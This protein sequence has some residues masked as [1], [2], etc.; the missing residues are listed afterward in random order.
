MPAVAGGGRRCEAAE[1]H[2]W[3]EHCQ[4]LSL[5]INFCHSGPRGSHVAGAYHSLSLSVSP[6]LP[7][8]SSSS[9]LIQRVGLH[10]S[11][12][13]MFSPSLPPS[14]LV[15]PCLSFAFA[16]FVRVACCFHFSF[17]P[18]SGCSPL[19]P[20]PLS[21][22]CLAQR[23]QG[24]LIWY[25]TPATKSST[26]HYVVHVHSELP[27]LPSSPLPSPGQSP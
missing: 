5:I 23:S 18:L 13:P 4:S 19:Y 26:F 7:S 6:S 15:S 9:P 21:L 14:S 17:L 27:P 3:R 8:P 24:E 11:V 12:P 1:S 16:S 22:L 25:A 20:S 10:R 2:R